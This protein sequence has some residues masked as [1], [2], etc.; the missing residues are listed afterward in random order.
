MLGEKPAGNRVKVPDYPSNRDA[1]KAKSGYRCAY[2]LLGFES[3]PTPMCFFPRR[4]FFLVGGI[5]MKTSRNKTKI[6]M[7][8]TMVT[9]FAMLLAGCGPANNA[10]ETTDPSLTVT[11]MTGREVSFEKTPERVVAITPAD[12][13]ILYA[14]GAIDTL[15]GIGKYVDYPE[16]ALDKTIV[17]SG[18]ELN[19]EQVLALEPDLIIMSD[20][21]HTEEQVQALTDAGVAVCV[22]SARSIEE[23]YEAVELIGTIMDKKENAENVIND[24][25]T[26]FDDIS[27]SKSKT[28]GKTVY[29]EVSPLEYGLWTA[30]KST[31]MQ[32]VADIVGLKNV[33]DDVDGWG[34]VSEEQVLERN[35]DYIVTITMYFGE[36]P[37]PVEEIKSRPGWENITAVKEDNILNLVNNELSRPAPRIKDGAKAL[38]DFIKERSK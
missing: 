3:R 32:E 18:S 13:E 15:V 16:E 17:E 12:T 38:S 5:I 26:T 31:F 34:E 14:V 19:A 22:T 8:V 11:D 33:F 28:E 21:D 29:F 6:F 20:M 10:T 9:I 36:G 30:G 7:L 23:V 4:K 1:F 27:K 37:T 35:P 24:M 25:K 2:Q